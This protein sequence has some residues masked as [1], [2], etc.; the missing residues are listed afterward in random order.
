MVLQQECLQI[1]WRKDRHK[2]KEDCCALGA[3]CGKC[4]EKN[5]YAKV[6]QNEER[7][8]KSDYRR[9]EKAQS[10]KKHKSKKVHQVEDSG[11]EEGEPLPCQL[12]CELY[13]SEDV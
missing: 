11:S 10:K 6:C 7:K 5:Q 4:G 12:D 2:K 8:D 9:D 13:R 1:L 3:T